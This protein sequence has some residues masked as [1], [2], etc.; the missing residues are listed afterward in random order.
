M[1]VV[2]TNITRGDIYFIDDNKITT[3]IGSEQRPGRP[4]IVVSNN[5]NNL[6]SH[7]V[8]IVYLT[9]RDKVPLPTHVKVPCRGTPSTALCEQ[10]CTVSTDRLGDFC[11]TVPPQLMR[12]VDAALGI[13][14]GLRLSN[15]EAADTVDD[16]PV[17]VPSNNNELQRELDT[18]TAKYKLLH[19]LYNNLL[20]KLTNA[21]G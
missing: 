4:G 9:T 1:R 7:T 10:I 14:L 21:A 5:A 2:K 13:S 17:D 16:T 3:T 20:D 19:G 15:N 6:N 12:Q 18:M 11:G 8:E